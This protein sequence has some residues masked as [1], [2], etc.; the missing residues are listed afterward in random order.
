M[1]TKEVKTR[2]QV[3]EL[4]EPSQVLP[5]LERQRAYSA[6]AFGFLEPPLFRESRWL[7]LEENGEPTLC[8]VAPGTSGQP[9]LFTLGPAEGLPPLL[10]TTALPQ[11]VYVHAELPHERV[12]CQH[13]KLAP[14]QTMIRM[15][16]T[17]A[18]FVLQ[19]SEASRL[20]A[21]HL[22]PVWQFYREEN[23]TD[24][25][26]PRLMDSVY[27]DSVYYGIWREGR[28]ASIAG[29]LLVSEAYGLAIVANVLTGR[30]YRNQGLATAVTSAVTAHLL[31]TCSLVVL[32]VDPENAPARRAYAKLGYQ[33]SGR[34]LEAMG[35]RRGLWPFSALLGRWR[36]RKGVRFEDTQS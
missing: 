19:E 10:E 36:Q 16:T 31:K 32:N 22:R 1:L 11:Q 3:S 18:T 28:L 24:L 4:K 26:L 7:L 29:T 33:E 20:G 2:S 21:S 25:P 27:M 15:A 9:T 12:L 6:L 17:P 5:Y 8:L 14:C 35:E 30:A 34:F 13:Y 23:L